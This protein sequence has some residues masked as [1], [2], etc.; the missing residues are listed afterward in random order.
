MNKMRKYVFVS[1]SILLTLSFIVLYLHVSIGGV[2]KIEYWYNTV[3]SEEFSDTGFNGIEC[4]AN[5]ESVLR[6]LGAPVL[7][8][9]YSPSNDEEIEVYYYTYVK[10]GFYFGKIGHVYGKILLIK[11]DI[12]IRKIDRIMPHTHLMIKYISRED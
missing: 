1:L 3:Y 7:I 4:G 2:P 10:D 12:V 8:R 5:T 11:K 9:S 6:E